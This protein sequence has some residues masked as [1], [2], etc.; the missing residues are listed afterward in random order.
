MT[1]Q[2]IIELINVSYPKIND[3]LFEQCTRAYEE[4]AAQVLDVP[5]FSRFLGSI[6]YIRKTVGYSVSEQDPFYNKIELIDAEVYSNIIRIDL[7]KILA[8]IIHAA[9]CYIDDQEEFE[10]DA[11][12]LII[13]VLVKYNRP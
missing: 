11:K 5:Q 4:N 6:L 10:P 2:Q 7:K 12:Q 1:M 8:Y 3:Y 9:F 13:A